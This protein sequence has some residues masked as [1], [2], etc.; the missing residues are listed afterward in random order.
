MYQKLEQKVILSGTS[1]AT[2]KS[3]GRSI[4]HI[5]LFFNTIPLELSDEVIKE[6]L[7]EIRSSKNPSETYFKHTVYGLRYLFR[8]FRRE[9]RAISLPQIERSN[10]LP[11]ILNRKEVLRLLKT[12][13]LLK[14]RVLLGLTYAAGLRLFEV[15]A[16]RI[17]DIDF[18]R[19]TVF[20][21]Q[22]KNGKSRYIPVEGNILRGIQKY[23][24]ACCPKYY[25]FNGQRKG[26]PM[27]KRGIQ[28]IMRQTLKNSNIQK[29][30]TLHT[31]RHSYAT[32]FLEDTGDLFSLKE[33][34]G[35][36]RLDTTL[37]YVHIVGSL[38]RFGA[39]SPLKKVMNRTSQS[40]SKA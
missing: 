10:K 13:K 25:L 9:D 26:E 37:I 31:L 16:L 29:E 20:V 28:F 11:V 14:H 5:S 12:P 4:A 40:K 21:E 15:A 36:A 18:E 8:L 34:L 32:H 30:I 3:Y 33:N 35:H 38:P 19:K 39:Y 6:Y 17:S 7:A 1:Q 23:L 2:L 22:G 27:S 24:H